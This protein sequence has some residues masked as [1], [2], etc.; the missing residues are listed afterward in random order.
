MKFLQSIFIL[1]LLSL[2]QFGIS[3]PKEIKKAEKKVVKLITEQKEKGEEFIS[4]GFSN[5][6]RNMGTYMKEQTE[7]SKEKTFQ[8]LIILEKLKAT[9]TKTRIQAWKSLEKVLAMLDLKTLQ[10]IENDAS[11]GKSALRNAPENLV[12]QDNNLFKFSELR[13]KILS[14]SKNETDEEVIE[15]SQKVLKL[16]NQ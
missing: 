2:P 4:S 8:L 13:E 9:D 5:M 14:G 3:Q 11:K 6:S 12:K 10:E 16:V 15:V 1:L 7:L